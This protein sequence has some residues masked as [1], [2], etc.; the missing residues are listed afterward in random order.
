M[1]NSR[2]NKIWTEDD[3]KYLIDNWG[4]IPPKELSVILE[5]TLASVYRK[6]NQLKLTM[7]DDQYEK[8]TGKIRWNDSRDKFLL[9]TYNKKTKKEVLEGLG[10]DEDKWDSVRKRAQV[11][12]AAEKRNKWYTKENLQYLEESWGVVSLKT[13]AKNLGT[14]ESALINMA[15]KMGLRD[16]MSADGSY[17]T[18]REIHEFTG[19]EL[20]KIYNWIYSS[21]LASKKLSIKSVKRYKI[22]VE[23]LMM[24]LYNNK[25]EYIFKPDDKKILEALI[26]GEKINYKIKESLLKKIEEDYDKVKKEERRPWSYADNEGMIDKYLKEGT[27]V[28]ELMEIYDRTENAIRS[29]LYKEGYSAKDRGSL[30]K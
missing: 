13:I 24:F 14:T 27:T 5:T 25:D 8:M 2:K 29:Q 4:I 9:K 26:K 18:V 11:I 12:G 3:T 19:I 6:A 7:T 22:K 23:T 16:Q 17:L 10:L 20:R 21:K 30:K 28:K 1:G 15:Y